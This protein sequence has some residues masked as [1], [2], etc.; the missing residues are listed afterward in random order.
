MEGAHPQLVPKRNGFWLAKKSH[1]AKHSKLTLFFKGRWGQL[2]V[3]DI[4]TP[5][6]YTAETFHCTV[7]KD[8]KYLPHISSL[9]VLFINRLEVLIQGPLTA[10]TGAS[11]TSSTGSAFLPVQHPKK[12]A[13][14]PV[15][16]LQ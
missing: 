13:I 9:L 14:V 5:N 11:T 8:P 3:W 1:I 6:L 10:A 15:S 4:A 12:W 7:S 2:R 16:M